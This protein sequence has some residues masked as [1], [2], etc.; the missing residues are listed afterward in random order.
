MHYATR[1]HVLWNA[2]LCCHHKRWDPFSCVLWANHVRPLFPRGHFSADWVGRVSPTRPGTSFSAPKSSHKIVLSSMWFTN[3]PPPHFSTR[4][5]YQSL[6][7]THPQPSSSGFCVQ[8]VASSTTN[9][10]RMAVPLAQPEL[11]YFTAKLHQT[12]QLTRIGIVL[13]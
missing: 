7:L 10:F 1:C 4:W 6:W 12:S 11:W 8:S 13:V 3:G 2:R 5:T 9:A